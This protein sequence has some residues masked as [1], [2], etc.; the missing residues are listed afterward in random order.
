MTLTKL[1]KPIAGLLFSSL[2]FFT[3]T[4][5]QAEQN[6][7]RKAFLQAEEY[8]IKSQYKR[9]QST[10]KDLHF[11]PLQPYLKQQ[12][13]I[14]QMRLTSA[15]E[16]D[17]FLKTYQGTPL[18]W[19]LRKKW[20]QYLAKNKQ[21]S[22]FLKFY[23]PTSDAKLACQFHRYQLQEG[24]APQVVMPA[25]TKL[26]V[27]GK[28]QPKVCDPL[29]E[30]W[31][32][33]GYRTNSVI[34]QRIEKTADGGKHTLLPYLVKLLPEA[35]RKQ[36]SL[37]QKVRVNPSY[38]AKLSRFPKKD[39][40]TAKIITYALRR[41]IWR[42][43]N[44]AIT[45]FERA[46]SSYPLNTQQITK[47]NEV[48]ALALASKGHS[49][50]SDWLAKLN[51]NQFDSNLIQWRITEILRSGDWS[52]V[53]NELLKLPNAV[54]TKL[55]WR[56]WY[57]RSLVASGNK[58]EGEKVLR[59]VASNRHYYGFLAAS[60]LN[61]PIQLN[62]I[63][64]EASDPEK[65]RVMNNPAAKRAFEFYYLGRYHQAR[66]EWNY[67]LKQLNKKDKLIAAKVANERG[68][69]D[70]AIFTL[71][72]TGYLND[73]DLRFPRAFEKPIESHSKKNKIDPAWAY[74]IARRESSFMTDAS[75]SAGA[76]GVMQILPGTAKQVAKRR[77][78]TSK[79]LTAEPNIQLGTKY[80]KQLLDRYDGNLVLA[81]A[82][83]NAGPN[84]VKQWLR[85]RPDLPIDMWIETI[86]FKE[87]REYVKSVMAYKQI[88]LWKRG[89]KTGLF[90]DFTQ[91]LTAQSL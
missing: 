41:Y 39:A 53:N 90:N 23:K 66:S 42:D 18:D 49:Q 10:Y 47:L 6:T 30:Q 45:T 25:I 65:Y 64:I 56:Y 55:Q 83:Y 21:S 31:Q 77:V 38:V 87:T 17:E 82:S 44:H 76:K 28:S 9:F 63:P 36:A 59:D 14:K 84:R 73:V 60:A 52:A 27:V 5:V 29:F 43:P 61:L 67:W 19:R 16:I 26:W 7:S 4:S 91:A 80:L 50:A 32:Q 48:F 8:L 1:T 57:G 89:N 51:E 46:K 79:L 34:W 11:Y 20:L 74:A 35:D 58:I 13:L 88:Y 68:W 86:P 33:A 2:F 75:S 24:L 22:L 78:P 85:A 15:G 72:N 70:R 37:W 40:M 81:T 12:Q 71:A 69:F 3:H 54:Q 62:D